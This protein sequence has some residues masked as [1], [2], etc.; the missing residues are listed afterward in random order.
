MEPPKNQGEGGDDD[1]QVNALLDDNPC[2]GSHTRNRLEDLLSII[3]RKTSI[4][5]DSSQYLVLNKPPDLRMDGQY[6][7]TVHKL[8]TYWYPPPS[9]LNAAKHVSEQDATTENDLIEHPLGY[10]NR[11]CGVFKG[12]IQNYK[13]FCIKIIIPKGS[14]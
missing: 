6:A 12:G 11:G 4:V 2:W 5:Y 1:D 14:F 13:G 7:S 3:D 9:L 8:L 10:G